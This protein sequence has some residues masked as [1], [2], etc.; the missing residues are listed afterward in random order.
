MIIKKAKDMAMQA[1]R[2]SEMLRAENEKLK[3]DLA[4]VAMMTD[5][6]IEEEEESGDESNVFEN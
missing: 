5:V 6:D 3:A 4:Y 2:D 1:V